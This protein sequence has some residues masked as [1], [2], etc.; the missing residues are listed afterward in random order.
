MAPFIHWW[1]TDDAGWMA[2]RK[3]D[4]KVLRKLFYSDASLSEQREYKNY[5][6][7]GEVLGYFPESTQFFLTPIQSK[8]DAY[9]FYW[10]NNFSDSIRSRLTGFP[11]SRSDF[12]AHVFPWYRPQINYFIAGILTNKYKKVM[13]R[14]SP[15]H[16]KAVSPSPTF[17]CLCYMFGANM[18]LTQEDVGERGV[19]ENYIGHMDCVEYFISILNYSDRKDK[20]LKK[21]YHLFIKNIEEA[22]D[23]DSLPEYPRQFAQDLYARLEDIKQSWES[24]PDM[25]A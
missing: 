21:D 1:K 18:V 24:E 11:I 4:W 16:I 14:T 12:H 25:D 7:T 13:E 22:R 10:S 17:W 23:N 20:E 5:F 15:N 9:A 6:L 19:I 8:E 2:Q 3:E